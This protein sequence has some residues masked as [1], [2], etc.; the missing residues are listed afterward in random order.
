MDAVGLQALGIVSGHHSVVV[1]EDL[2]GLRVHNVLH[3]IATLQAFTEGL[4]D[5]T[6]LHDL[7]N[8]DAVVSA[9]VMLADNDLLGYVHQTAGQITGVSGPQCRIGQTL[10]GA[11]AG[12]EVFQ[13]G[14]SFT[15]VGLNGDLDGA[16]GGI[17]HQATHA[18]QLADLRGGTTGAGVCHHPDRV[19]AVQSG[20]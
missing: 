17:G 18:S 5:L 6:V 12:D 10:S 9:A 16:A 19:V 20:H 1:N 14:E 2:A 13:Y 15:E 4:D 7:R 11:S 3:G 8:Q